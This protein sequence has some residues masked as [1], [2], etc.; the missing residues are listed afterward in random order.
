MG[1]Q[2]FLTHAGCHMG[3]AV[4]TGFR[5]RAVELKRARMMGLRTDSKCPLCQHG[6]GGSHIASGARQENGKMYTSRHNAL[7]RQA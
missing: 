1:A 7:S 6:D 2:P 4:S 3:P 5:G